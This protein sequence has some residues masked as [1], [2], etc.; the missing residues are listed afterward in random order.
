MFKKSILALLIGLFSLTVF[1]GEKLVLLTSLDPDKNR[2]RFRSRSWDINQKLENIFYDRLTPYHTTRENIKIIHFATIEDLTRELA[3]PENKAVFWVSHSNGSDANSVLDRNIVVDYQG[4]DLSEGFQNPSSKLQFLG[5]VGCFAD[6]LVQR[7][8]NLG[9][10]QNNEHLIINSSTKKVDARRALKYAI[11]NYL[12]HHFEG[13][14][15]A[16]EKACELV[17]RKSLVIRRTIPMDV[18]E[19]QYITAIKIMQRDRLIGVFPKG[20]PG[21]LQELTVNLIPGDNK[22]DIKLVF[23]SGIA[24]NQ[25]AMG[26]FEILGT[27]YQVF[28]TRDGRPLGKGRYVFNYKGN[29][30]DL[31]RSIE[32]TKQNCIE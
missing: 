11:G 19:E 12:Y 32:T 15:K 23:D 14:L 31:P 24:S 1:A 21:E 5:F 7:N 3:D 26:E 2:P 4:K 18:S 13:N 27:D 25:I 30:E 29:I 16:S 28:S 9:Y 22:R 10:M 20:E 17:E 8:L 6:Y